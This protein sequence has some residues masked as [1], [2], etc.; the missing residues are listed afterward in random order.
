L[1]ERFR[2]YIPMGTPGMIDP[3]NTSCIYFR[4]SMMFGVL[5]LAQKWRFKIAMGPRD[6]DSVV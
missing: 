3:G 4:C 1:G 5:Q 2:V 6:G